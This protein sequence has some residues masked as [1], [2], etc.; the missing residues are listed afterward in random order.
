M[1]SLWR[2]RKSKAAES[3][4]TTADRTLQLVRVGHRVAASDDA[5]LLR[6]DSADPD[7]P[8]HRFPAGA[9]VDLHVRPGL[10][11]QY[12]LVGAPGAD[13]HYLVCVQREPDGRGGSLA[14]H[15]DLQTGT[16]LEVSAPRSTFELVPSASSALLIGGGI[17]LT[18]LVSMAEHLHREE[19]EFDFHVYARNASALPLHEDLQTRPWAHRI[20]RHFSDDGDSFRSIAP[21]ALA[22]PTSEGAVYICGPT[23]FIDLARS[24]AITAGWPLERIVSERFAPGD[25]LSG[26]GTAFDVI[27]ASTGERMTVGANETIADVLESRGYETYRSCA[28]G[29][30]GSCVATVRSGI[31]DHRDDFQTDAQRAANGHINI[32]VSRSL[33]PILELD[34]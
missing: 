5:V 19:M 33:T 13:D 11:R 18:P 17:G 23:G 2:S 16:Q 8:L 9:H 29:Y 28:Q 32:C 27:A 14:V 12:S 30:C 7:M 34:I 10:V 3:R 24:R 31:P 21:P 4:T 15:D 25:S 22:S 26:A 1:V 6:L 20:Q